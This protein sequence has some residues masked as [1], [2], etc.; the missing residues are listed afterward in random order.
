MVKKTK[1]KQSATA[2]VREIKRLYRDLTTLYNMSLAKAIEIGKL[3]QQ[4]KDDLG[5][6][7][8]LPWVDKLPFSR[9]SATNY[10]SLYKHR[11]ELK[12]ARVADLDLNA[13]YKVLAN[14]R[15]QQRD[16]MRVET[17]KN[18]KAFADKTSKFSNPKEV[19]YIN[20]AIAGDNLP[21]MKQMAKNGMKGKYTAIICSP[22][23]NADFYYGKNYDDNKSYDAYLQDLLKRFPLYSKL[24]RVGGRVIY[25]VGNVV[26]NKQRKEGEDYN[27][28]IVTDLEVGVRKVAPELKFF[29]HIIWDKGEGGKFPLNNQWGTFADPKTP[30]TRCCHENILIWSNQQ[31]ELENIEGTKPDITPEEFKEWAWSV[32]KISPYVK[33][34]NPHP[35]SFPP[36]LIERLLKFYTHPNDLILDPYAGVSTTAEICKKFNRRYTTV[37]LNPN[38]VEH[39]SDRLKSA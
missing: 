34:N 6:G 2:T 1:T 18:R 8:W 9:R 3:L 31:F 20:R 13:A 29:N 33:P 38:Y 22:G 25:N 24:L 5:H 14:Y 10:I 36:K 26:K 16:K 7:Q 15:N 23:Y 12:R 35:C 30:V 27:Y 28:Q 37:D 4:Q 32:W 11:A 21:T 17:R 39:A 19:D